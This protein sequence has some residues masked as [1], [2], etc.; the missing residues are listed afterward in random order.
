MSI[1]EPALRQPSLYEAHCRPGWGAR[2]R[3]LGLDVEYVRAE[4][5][6]LWTSDSSGP[7]RQVLD[8]VG[9]FGAGLFGH[10]HP[11]LHSEANRRQAQ[12]VEACAS[13]SSVNSSEGFFQL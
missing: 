2:F 13:T 4:K 8:L 1:A 12:A 9:G 11:A 10:N 3:A 7:S 5:D 6:T